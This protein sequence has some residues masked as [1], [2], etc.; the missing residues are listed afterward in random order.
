MSN[1]RGKQEIEKRQAFLRRSRSKNAWN[2]STR[3]LHIQK[4]GRL[5]QNELPDIKDPQNRPNVDIGRLLRP[6]AQIIKQEVPAASASKPA[7]GSRALVSTSILKGSISR[8]EGNRS[9]S[10]SLASRL[11]QILTEKLE[12]SGQT[13][14]NQLPAFNIK[15]E[16]LESGHRLQR[17]QGGSPVNLRIAPANFL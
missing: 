5:P 7:L 13:R 10:P 2:S 17:T 12:S 16:N 9:K 4:L 8:A 6:Q 3:V 11:P 1:N 15:I 14:A